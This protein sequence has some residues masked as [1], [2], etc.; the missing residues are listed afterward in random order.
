[1]RPLRQ[2]LVGE[3]A[4]SRWTE[5]RQREHALLQL[6]QREL[7]KTLT[8]HVGAVVAGAQELTLIATSGAAAALLRQHAPTLLAALQHGG[9]K[10][11][12]IRIRVQ[13]R[14]AP[15]RPAKALPK[16]IDRDTAA[17]L[18]AAA[19]KLEDPALR[20]ALLRLAGRSAGTVARADDPLHDDA[21]SRSA[22]MGPGAG[23]EDG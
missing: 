3:A 16:Q 21:E 19:R 1:M 20:E 11:T 12:V 22:P 23:E 4:L 17:R 2:I 5:R 10:F 15:P 6:V 18:T 8:P 7:P 13:A 9:C 14:S